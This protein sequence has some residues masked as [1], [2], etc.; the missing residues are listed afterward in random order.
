[1]P[2]AAFALPGTVEL[3]EKALPALE[4]RGACLLENHGV[5]AVGESLEQAYLRAVYTEDAARICTL[6][7]LNGPVVPLPEETVKQIRES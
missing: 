5:L 7:R 3:G 2:L 1:M 4:Q 6:A